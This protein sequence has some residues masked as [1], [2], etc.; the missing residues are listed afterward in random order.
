MGV[1]PSDWRPDDLWARPV[2]GDFSP[3]PFPPAADEFLRFRFHSTFGAAPNTITPRPGVDQQSRPSTPPLP[4][5]DATPPPAITHF[6]PVDG[7]SVSP[8]A[9]YSS[10]ADGRICAAA[11]A[12]RSFNRAR[13]QPSS[14]PLRPPPTPRKFV[15]RIKIIIEPTL[16]SRVYLSPAPYY[17][18]SNNNNIII[19][20]Q[21]ISTI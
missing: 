7:T 12:V 19:V 4:P 3:T 13:T 16:I 6:P 8:T 17:Y 1:H 10:A 15:H 5:P 11:A 9:L 18:Y 14:P 20:N 21:V 2:V